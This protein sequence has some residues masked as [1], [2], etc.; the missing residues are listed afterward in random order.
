MRP[1]LV[2]DNETVVDADMARR[3][4]GDPALS[5]PDALARVAPPRNE[6]EAYSFPK[7]LYHRV[8]EI[9][10]CVV[11]AEGKVETLKPLRTTADERTL[12]HAFWSGFGR[13]S[14]TRLVTYN[15]RKFDLPVL[16]QRALANGVSPAPWWTGDYRQRF[17]DSHL[18]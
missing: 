12:L 2:F 14:G 7:P 11:N 4:V 18:D 8:V 17:R 13:H 5:D 3:V 6:G 15:G 16:V 1:V 9:S 10:V